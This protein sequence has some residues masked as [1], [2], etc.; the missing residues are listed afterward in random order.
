M[1]RLISA[2]AETFRLLDAGAR[3]SRYKSFSRW[4]IA[5]L[6]AAAEHELERLGGWSHAR[7]AVLDPK[8]KRDRNV[9]KASGLG[10]LCTKHRA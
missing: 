9:L 6:A 10:K 1:R 7:G 2:N 5:K 8:R 4:A 3:A